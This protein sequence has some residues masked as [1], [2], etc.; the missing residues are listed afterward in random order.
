MLLEQNAIVLTRT[1]NTLY[2]LY[3]CP[4]VEGKNAIHF[5]LST[6][7]GPLIHFLYPLNPIYG[8]RVAGAHPSCHWVRGRVLPGHVAGPLQGHT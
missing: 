5:L 2:T 8:D 4:T 1:G 3:T 6:T 7:K